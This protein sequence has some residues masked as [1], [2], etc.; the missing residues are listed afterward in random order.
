MLAK[1]CGHT[2]FT[3]VFSSAVSNIIAAAK[4]V[5]AAYRYESN[6]LNTNKVPIT[7][8]ETNSPTARLELSHPIPLERLFDLTKVE[9]K[10]GSNV[11]TAPVANPNPDAPR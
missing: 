10:T 1:R 11:S 7:M 9:V 8:L 3:P 5:T 6:W 4:A 2:Y